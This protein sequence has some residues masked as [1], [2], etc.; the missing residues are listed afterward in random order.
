MSLSLPHASQGGAVS[1]AA[2]VAS[3]LGVRA[4]VVTA[5]GPDADLSLFE[6]HDL[7]VVRTDA[8]LTF[9]H[10]YTFWGNKRKLRVTAQ[11]NV[12]LTMEHVPRRC[13]RARVVLLGPLTPEVR[14]RLH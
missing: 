1:Y 9:E 11:P 5:N 4:C 2:A 13:R 7:H 3:A 12:T 14:A 10:T 6:G 8:T